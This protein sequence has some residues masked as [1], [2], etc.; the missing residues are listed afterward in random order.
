MNRLIA[1]AAAWWDGRT[2]RERRMLTVMGVAIAAVL[3]WLLIVRPLASWRDEAARTR[4][5]AEAELTA[6]ERGTGSLA[7]GDAKAGEVDVSA[8]VAEVDENRIIQVISNLIS[9]AIKY[10]DGGDITL[11]AQLQQDDKQ[12]HCLVLSVADTG[13][14]IS[15]EHHETIFH[16]FSQVDT[17]V[18]R[19]SNGI[20]IG[21]SFVQKLV[22]ILGGRI[23]LQ[24]TPD[25][26]SLFQVYLPQ[27]NSSQ[28]SH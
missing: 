10:T 27:P 19:R 21:L 6:I 25:Q 1:Q 4:A 28:N 23:E 16:Q 18:A 12:G 24:S 3:A 7:V 11:G 2:L 8:A 15:P 22:D 13:I 9:N 26:G 5:T 14:G 20:G 17:S